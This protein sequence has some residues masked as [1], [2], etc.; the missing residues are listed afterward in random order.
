MNFCS[1]LLIFLQR[2]V[3][4]LLHCVVILKK[5]K[6]SVCFLLFFEFIESIGSEFVPFGFCSFDAFCMR[7]S[8][9]EILKQIIKTIN[10]TLNVQIISPIIFFRTQI[11]LKF[12]LIMLFLLLSD[13]TIGYPVLRS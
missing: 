13:L 8:I 6:E 2:F 11:P 10:P 3:V 9:F 5:L 1:H 12:I 7:A 4:L